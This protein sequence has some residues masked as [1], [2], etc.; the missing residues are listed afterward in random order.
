MAFTINCIEPRAMYRSVKESVEIA[1]MGQGPN[2]MNRCH[3]WGAPRVPVLNVAGGDEGWALSWGSNGQ[4]VP[5]E[6]WARDTMDRV[7]SGTLK[8]IEYWD[9]GVGN[10]GNDH[11]GQQDHQPS[12]KRQRLDPEP[13]PEVH[14]NENEG[15]WT[16]GPDPDH[17]TALDPPPP[18]TTGEV[19]NAGEMEPV[20]TG[21]AVEMADSCDT[22]ILSELG[23]ERMEGEQQGSAGGE[24]KQPGLQ[25][26][27]VDRR[28]VQEQPAIVTRTRCESC[29]PTQGPGGKGPRGPKAEKWA[30]KGK[31]KDPGKGKGPC[32]GEK[33]ASRAGSTDQLGPIR[34]KPGTRRLRGSTLASQKSEILS[35]VKR[36]GGEGGGGG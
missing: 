6:Q 7:Q 32:Q 9:P 13:E 14:E 3:E 2:T 31:P 22:P 5:R 35:W 10:D 21:T 36:G 4:E 27:H 26:D 12:T 11:E 25:S 33:P 30:S 8:R 19:V 17:G 29:P 34:R 23:C 18:T 28:A 16:D 24:E 1:R 20:P 15:Q